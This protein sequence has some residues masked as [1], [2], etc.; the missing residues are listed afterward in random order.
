[1]TISRWQRAFQKRLGIEAPLGEPFEMADLWPRVFKQKPPASIITKLGK[2]GRPSKVVEAMKADKTPAAVAP[3]PLPPTDPEA[4]DFNYND[5]VLIAERNLQ[6][7]ARIL[8]IAI[9]TNDPIEIRNAQPSYQAASEVLR[10]TKLASAKISKDDGDS[11]DAA[12]VRNEIH[13]IHA[14]IPKTLRT[15]L[16]D[17]LSAFLRSNVVP[18]VDQMRTAV[19]TAIDSAFAHLA[20]STFLGE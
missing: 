7:C 3:A 1:M 15:R 12:T 5:S 20:N 11:F 6:A 13:R 14:T 17:D 8:D 2:F 9:A 16:K 4:P 19:D 18:T 10:K